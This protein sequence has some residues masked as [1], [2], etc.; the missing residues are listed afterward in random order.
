MRT[1]G[2][3]SANALE[4]VANP[5]EIVERQRPPIDL[6]PEQCEV[7]AAVVN[8][9]PADWFTP[10]NSYLLV[11]YCREI[12]EANF[13]AGKIEATKADE[14]STLVDYLLLRQAQ[15]KQS[16]VIESLA[17]KMRI[18]QQATTNHRGNKQA[19]VQGRKLNSY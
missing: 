13:I 19:T 6:T 1:R 4:I 12:S 11:Q 15:E 14:G 18:S 2:R 8:C 5:L 17:T 7:W 10:A 3:V 16:R 9:Q